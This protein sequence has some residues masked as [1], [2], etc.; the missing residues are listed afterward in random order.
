[1]KLTTILVP[2]DGSALAETAL[3]KAIELAQASGAGLLLLRAAQAHTLPGADPTEA[4]I[5]VMKEAEA[6]LAGV[7]ERL[8]TAGVTGVATSVWYGPPATAVIEAWAGA[9]RRI[10]TSCW[11]SMSAPKCCWP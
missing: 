4:Q 9:S 11:V 7:V 5:R 6:Y 2:L 1:M 8:G 3:P 10:S